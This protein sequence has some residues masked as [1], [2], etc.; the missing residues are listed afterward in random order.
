MQPQGAVSASLGGG[1]AVGKGAECMG[2]LGIQCCEAVNAMVLD[3]GGWRLVEHTPARCLRD[4]CK[5]ERKRVW[6]NFIAVSRQ[7]HNWLWPQGN[8]LAFFFTHAQWGVTVAWLRQMSRRLVHRFASFRGEAKIHLAEAKDCGLD[9]HIPTKANLKLF[10]VWLLWRAVRR[11]EERFSPMAAG[12][13]SGTGVNLAAAPHTLLNAMWEWYP[14]HMLDKRIEFCRQNGACLEKLVVDGNLKL[15]V[16]ICGRPMAELLESRLLGLLT[17]TPCSC[18]PAYKKRRCEKHAS[19]LCG[20]SAAPTQSEVVVSHRHRASLHEEHCAEPYDVK[21]VARGMMGNRNPPSRWCPADWVT[22]QQLDE[23]W[24][25]QEAAGFL[26]AKT[27]SSDLTATA[28]KTHKENNRAYANLIRQGR[29]NGWLIATTSSGLIVHAKPFVGAESVSQRYFFL[30]ELAAKLPQLYV[31]IH[32]DACHVRRFADKHAHRSD[33]GRRLAFPAV[34]Y[35]TDSFH[36][37]GHIDPWCLANCHPSAPGNA[38][39]VAGVKTSMCETVNSVVGR[40]KF[41]L[42]HMRGRTSAFFMHEVID[43]RNLLSA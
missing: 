41:M 39:L 16:R 36:A 37:S 28:C 33:L 25:T 40:H 5:L 3:V 35:I 1:T 15:C 24:A 13:A 27:A 38:E 21:L 22:P 11:I 4:G 34:H 12:A 32:D 43:I 19:S 26:A 18:P 20:P 31:V 10:R 14:N 30:A 2:A 7:E 9:Q 29:L 23:Y 6:Y 42:R 8:T 17:T